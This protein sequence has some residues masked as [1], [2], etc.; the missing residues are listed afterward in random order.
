MKAIILA[1]GQSERFGKPKAFAQINSQ[2]FYKRIIEVLEGTNLFNEI[3]ISTNETLAPQFDYPNIAIDD[4]ENKDKGPMA[5]IY[6][7]MRQH[8]D[9]TLFFVI[10]VDTPMITQKA[11]SKLYQFMIEHLIEDQLNIAGFQE[12]GM[13][14]PTMAFY[15]PQTLPTI[16]TALDSGDYSLKNVYSKVKSDWLDVHE[17]DSSNYWY[18]NINYKQD[19]EDL[20]H[21]I[22]NS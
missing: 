19:L 5:G 6:S 4:A 12:K 8:T 21:D 7:V 18:K 3:I 22:M 17:I 20:H 11:I 10:S 13:P 15:S 2:M 9:E 14:I 1:G 16:E